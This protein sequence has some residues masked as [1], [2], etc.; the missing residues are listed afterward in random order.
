MHDELGKSLETALIGDEADEIAEA[1]RPQ[2]QSLDPADPICVPVLVERRRRKTVDLEI[3]RRL[4]RIEVI[5][6]RTART[7]RLVLVGIGTMLLFANLEYF[8]IIGTSK[9]PIWA[10]A[11]IDG[12]RFAF[13][14]TQ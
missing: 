1:T 11:V 9:T 14:G 5:V 4:I 7:T 8:G 10:T 2:P 3:D 12:F 13:G 6:A